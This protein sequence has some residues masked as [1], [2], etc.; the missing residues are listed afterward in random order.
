MKILLVGINAKFIQQYG[1][2]GYKERKNRRKESYVNNSMKH[3][4]NQ[5]VYSYKGQTLRIK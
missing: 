1:V 5:N 2:N 4:R 3:R